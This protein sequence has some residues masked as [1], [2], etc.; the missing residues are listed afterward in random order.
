MEK[1]INAYIKER[2]HLG[3]VD[4]RT[5]S[6]L[7]LAYIGDGIYDLV[8]RSVVVGRGNTKAGKLHQTTSQLVKSACAVGN[9][10]RDRAG[11]D[12]GRK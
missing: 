9:D 10:A 11:A 2:F 3:D 4:I 5:Y 1:G 12:R 6:P 7:T 8:I